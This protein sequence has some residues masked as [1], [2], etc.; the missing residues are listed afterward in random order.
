MENKKIMNEYC[1]LR[2]GEKQKQLTSLEEFI[3]NGTYTINLLVDDKSLGLPFEFEGEEVVHLVVKEQTRNANNQNDRVVVQTLTRV[4]RVTGHVL[5]Y[6]RT[7]RYKDGEHRW[8]EWVG[9]DSGVGGTIAMDNE[10]NPESYNPVQN[11]AIAQALEDAVAKGRELAKRDLYIA[12]GAL[13][14]DTDEV[15]KRTAFWGEEVDHLPKH[16][17]LNGLGDI[18]EEEVNRI[19]SLKEAIT[20]LIA[21]GTTVGG[22]IFQDVNLPRTLFGTP[23][24]GRWTTNQ[25]IAG[26]I[27][28]SSNNNLEIV[29]WT[30][31]SGLT[32]VYSASEIIKCDSNSFLLC[33]KLRV[34][35]RCQTTKVTDWGRVPNI[36]E[37]RLHSLQYNVTLSSNPKISKASILYMI[38]NVLKTIKTAIVITLNATTYAKCVDGGEWHEEVQTALNVANGIITDGGSV[39]LANA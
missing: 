25:S 12:A 20:Q 2:A 34:I 3:W 11:K 15:I 24:T 17:Y 28:F 18:T 8:G 21:S 22:R 13:Y 10:I 23:N 38:E 14:N 6:T 37:L 26:N 33:S 1:G 16:Y 39:N 35:D 9:S 29:K 31:T 30:N 4:N 19:Y 36:E 32:P 27:P 5:T 7:R